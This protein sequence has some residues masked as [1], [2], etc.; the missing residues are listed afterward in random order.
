MYYMLRGERL[1]RA[2]SENRNQ[3]FHR[4]LCRLPFADT[5]TYLLEFCSD[6][7]NGGTTHSEGIRACDVLIRIQARAHT[8][9][10]KQLLAQKIFFG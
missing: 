5:N 4:C 3:M 6:K 1:L 10:E 8:I 2:S 7:L 9:K